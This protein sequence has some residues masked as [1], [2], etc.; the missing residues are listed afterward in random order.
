[1]SYR[2]TVYLGRDNEIALALAQGSAVV[3]AS[4]V[5][6]VQLVFKR[7]DQAD[8]VIDSNSAPEHFDL[9]E[10]GLVNGISTGILVL[11]LG[12]VDIDE[13]LYEVAIYLFDAQNDDGVFW[14]SIEMVVRD[15]DV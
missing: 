1:M 4:G 15:G 7:P 14:D 3:D 10:K 6:R 8:V 13:D 5:T 2:E 11:K 12:E 9:S